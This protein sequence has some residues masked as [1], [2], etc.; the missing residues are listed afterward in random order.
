[1]KQ[2]GIIV[3]TFN[4]PDT[5][6]FT[7]W[8]HGPHMKDISRI[9]GLY[10]VR[11]YQVVEGPA[12]RRGYLAVLEPDDLEASMAYRKTPEGQRPQQDSN[13]RGTTD[14]YTLSCREIFSRTFTEAAPASLETRSGK[15]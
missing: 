2:N 6:E 10:K 8:V 3:V 15:A 13:S 7:D 4:T 14:R 11:R 12:D 5:K 1:M 9:P